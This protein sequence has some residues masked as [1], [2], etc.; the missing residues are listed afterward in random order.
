MLCRPQIV[1]VLRAFDHGTEYKISRLMVLLAN[2]AY[3][4]HA[5]NIL[6]ITLTLVTSPTSSLQGL[7]LLC[8]QRPP[9]KAYACVPMKA[10]CHIV[11]APKLYASPH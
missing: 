7:R 2:K 1:L 6:P 5:P 4:C 9:Y 3:V 8:P 10:R 11:F